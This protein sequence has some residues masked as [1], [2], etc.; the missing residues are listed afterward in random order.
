MNIEIQKHST[1]DQYISLVV[2]DPGG[3]WTTTVVIDRYDGSL[4]GHITRDKY[5]NY[6][7]P[8]AQGR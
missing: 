7:N 3:Q 6:A 2:T 4:F 1:A 8:P 5:G